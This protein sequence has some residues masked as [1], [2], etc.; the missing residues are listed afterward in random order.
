M[1]FIAA[2]GGNTHLQP[3][4]NPYSKKPDF[5]VF[6]IRNWAFLVNPIKLPSTS[7]IIVPNEFTKKDV[8]WI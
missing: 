5:L 1:S 8:F 7:Q 4:R 2:S 3:Y 6:I